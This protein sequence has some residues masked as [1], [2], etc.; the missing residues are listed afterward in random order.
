MK[1]SRAMPLLATVLLASAACAT[2]PEPFP[3]NMHPF[4]GGPGYRVFDV[5]ELDSIDDAP[6]LWALYQ[7]AEE[8][9]GVTRSYAPVRVFSASRIDVKI[10]GTWASHYVGVWVIEPGLVYFKHG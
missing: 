5:D 9:T 2:G 10:D 6:V 7:M 8:C 1:F 3:P 4:L